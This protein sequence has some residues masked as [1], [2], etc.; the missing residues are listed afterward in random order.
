MWAWDETFSYSRTCRSTNWS[1]AP[2]RP[3][4]RTNTSGGRCSGCRA[5]GTPPGSWRRSPAT[6]RSGSARSPGATTP[7]DLV[8]C[9][10]GSARDRGG[11]PRCSR[12]RCRR[13]CGR[14]WQARRRRSIA[15]AAARWRSGWRPGSGVRSRA[16]AAGSISASASR[17]RGT[18]S[19]GRAT[20]RPT[21]ASRRPSKK[22]RP[23]VQAVATA[24][25]QAA[26]ELWATDEHRIG[27]KP[28]L[29][30]AW[31]PIGSR[32]IVRV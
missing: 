3:K 18:G 25:P 10:T 7:R 20:P 2:A 6:R 29:R 31:A 22:L 14:R 12:R 16:P 8:A 15:G 11:R 9:T 24:F 17:S 32:P 28:L 13:N 23:L 4:T 27:L 26:V 19:R 21:R 30:R 1:G 5:R